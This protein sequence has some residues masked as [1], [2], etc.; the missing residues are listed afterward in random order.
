M[1]HTARATS[2]DTHPR[3]STLDR[4][5]LMRLAETEYERVAELLDDLQ[6]A[7]WT[8]PTDC[9]GWDVRAMAGHVLGMAEMAASIR[10]T[11]RQQ[12][13][14]SKR[15]GLPLDALTALQV[16]EHAHLSPSQL[17]ERLHDVGPRAFRARRR[18]PGL[19]RRF[20]LPQQQLVGDQFE[21][22]TLGFLT[23]TI[24]TRDPWMHRV[25]ISRAIDRPIHLTSDHDGVLVADVVTEWAGRHGCPCRLTLSGP[26]GGEWSF[27]SGGPSLDLDAV[28]FC[29][30]VSGRESPTGVLATAVP[31]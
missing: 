22:W 5:A 31:F 25:D 15:G 21:T 24:L 28:E 6:P 10:E 20:R 17:A 9:P 16:E 2:H 3:V 19:V 12:K 8:R 11:R 29:R 1:T 18:T 7:D 14:A 30:T 23:D 26:A 4:P 13:A 27:G